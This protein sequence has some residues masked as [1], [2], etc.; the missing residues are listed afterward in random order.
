MQLAQTIHAAGESAA[1]NNV[2]DNTHAIALHATNEA[3]L[4]C[5]EAKLIAIGI[6]FKAIR[7]PDEPYNGQLMA[8]GIPPQPRTKKLKKLF[9][10]FKLAK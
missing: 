1:N 10:E 8:I 3:E 6:R 4:A 7:E 5:L 2:P 9:Q